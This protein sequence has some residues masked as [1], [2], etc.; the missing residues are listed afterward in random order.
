MK[1][2]YE[3]IFCYVSV[4]INIQFS[5]DTLRKRDKRGYPN[6]HNVGAQDLSL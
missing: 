6:L 3:F 2:L 4:M 1:H 5:K